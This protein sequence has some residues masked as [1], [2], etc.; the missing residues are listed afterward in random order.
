MVFDTQAA[1][2]RLVRYW[3]WRYKIFGDRLACLPMTLQGA[4]R[5]PQDRAALNMALVQPMPKDQHGRAVLYI[6]RWKVPPTQVTRESYMRVVF[7]VCHRMA[8]EQEVAQPSTLLSSR[9]N[10]HRGVVVV[11]NMRSRDMSQPVDRRLGKDM[12]E[13]FTSG[14]PLKL[15]AMHCCLQATGRN[16]Y[17][18]A[19]PAYKQL[20]SRHI[21]LRTV[22]HSC[23]DANLLA[24][25]DKYGIAADGV[26][27]E[28]GGTFGENNFVSWLRSTSEAS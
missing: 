18:L 25:L 12:A 11:L 23:C 13:L 16:I 1:A 9:C 22:V 17:G 24:R 4:L 19:L 20:L 2:L 21:R 3:N 10:R 14:L 5:D 6:N 15:Q 7:Y 28:L 8:Q 27:V 26:P